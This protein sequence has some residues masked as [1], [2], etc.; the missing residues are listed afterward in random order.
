MVAYLTKPIRLAKLQEAI[1]AWIRPAAQGTTA[2]PEKYTTG[3]SHL[4]ADLGVVAAMVGDD[5]IVIDDM[6]QEFRLSGNKA[7]EELKRSVE[8]GSLRATE[9]AT[10]SLKSSARA[11]GALELGDLC[12]EIEQAALANN[13]VEVAARLSRFKTVLA[14][15]ILLLDSR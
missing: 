3:A 15:L 6:L 9:E 10:H 14:R 13:A 12:D 2:L 4:P 8:R 1:E 5:P 7:S 11:I